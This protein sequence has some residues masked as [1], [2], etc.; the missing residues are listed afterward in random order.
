MDILD[1]FI[2]YLLMPSSLGLK[3]RQV[4]SKKFKTK[5]SVKSGKLDRKSF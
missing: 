2:I 1:L 5:K 4:A 3:K